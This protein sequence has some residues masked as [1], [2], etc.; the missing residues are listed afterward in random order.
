M[1]K[2]QTNKLKWNADLLK[3]GEMIDPETDRV[4][5]DY[6][7]DR[8]I[9]YDNVG[10]TVTDKHFSRQDGNEIM[11]KIETRLD[12]SIEEKQEEYRVRIKDVVYNIERIYVRVDDRIMELSLAYAN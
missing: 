1:P 3:L 11:K 6:L 5:Y 8:N 12:R 4:V 7:L 10:I 9:K 2:R